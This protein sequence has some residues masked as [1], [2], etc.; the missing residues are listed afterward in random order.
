MRYPPLDSLRE[1]VSSAV[2]VHDMVMGGTD[3]T[4]PV[5]AGGGVKAMDAVSAASDSGARRSM[6]VLTTGCR[7]LAYRKSSHSDCVRPTTADTI[8][9]S[10]EVQL[11]KGPPRAPAARKT[12]CHDILGSAIT[13]IIL[14]SP[15]LP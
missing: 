5:R 8:S 13:I 14:Q 4:A 10:S 7:S 1:A 2:S 12:V 6:A 3:V 9:S 11:S 15:I